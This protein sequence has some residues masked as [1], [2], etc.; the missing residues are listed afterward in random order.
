M[1]D[2]TIRIST[3]NRKALKRLQPDVGE[4][5]DDVIQA[6]VEEHNND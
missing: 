6:L 1:T 3:T 4:T 2:T 5:Y